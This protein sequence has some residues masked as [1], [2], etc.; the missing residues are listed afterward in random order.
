MRQRDGCVSVGLLERFM[1]TK[2]SPGPIQVFFLQLMLITDKTVASVSN[3][4]AC[5]DAHDF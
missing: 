2:L 4:S 3:A 5:I 1:S